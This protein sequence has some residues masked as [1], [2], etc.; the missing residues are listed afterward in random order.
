M[1]GLVFLNFSLLQEHVR[2]F[3]KPKQDSCKYCEFSALSKEAIQEH[4][5]EAHEEYVILHT[6][7]SQVDQMSDK[8]THFESFGAQ[9]M[10]FLKSI[11]GSQN[12]MKHEISLLKNKQAENGARPQKGP[13]QEVPHNAEQRVDP[14][15]AERESQP[16]P[17]WSTGPAPSSAPPPP[18]TSRPAYYKKKKS[19]YLQKPKVLLIGDS[20]ANSAN[21]AHVEK[22]TKS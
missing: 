12:E 22:Q 7:A 18:P 1:C 2:E 14:Q 20:V 5:I 10:N 17:S 11:H 13:Y 16:P 21:F 9:V 15:R 4:M 19:K 6:M 3:H 8:F